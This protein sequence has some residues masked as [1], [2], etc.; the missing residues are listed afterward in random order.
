[1]V[2]ATVAFAVVAL[3]AAAV[4]A[5]SS[6]SSS[7]LEARDF[8]NDLE[9]REYIVDDLEAREPEVFFE[10]VEAR[11]PEFFDDIEAREYQAEE[12]EARDFEQE[13]FEARAPVPAD[14]TPTPTPSGSPSKTVTITATPVPTT[15]T[16]KQLK[17]Q[18]ALAVIKAAKGKTNLTSDE[19]LKVKKAR[20][21]LSRVRSRKSRSAKRVVKQCGRTLRK[22]KL[23]SQQCTSDPSQC[24]SALTAKKLTTAKCQAAAQYLRSAKTSKKSKKGS[25][26]S[27]VSKKSRQLSG[28]KTSVGSDGVTTVTVNA[29]PI[30][31]PASGSGSKSKLRKR[32]FDSVFA[33]EYD[34]DNLD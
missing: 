4:I 15:C 22:A 7:Q 18:Q 19:K 31:T 1:M 34:Y 25:K 5:Q 24:D 29:G 13:E 23:T 27:R 12:L 3:G 21:Y 26:S 17:V 33:R 20:K 16:K 10:D 6:E 32:E 14:P 30:C 9:V 2:R 28:S 8:D 11:E